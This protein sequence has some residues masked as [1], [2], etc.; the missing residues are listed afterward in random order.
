MLQSG[1]PAQN[2]CL[3][4]GGARCGTIARLCHIMM[5]LR[6]QLFLHHLFRPDSTVHGTPLCGKASGK[7]DPGQR[8]SALPRINLSLARC[9]GNNTTQ[10]GQQAPVRRL[11]FLASCWRRKAIQKP[12]L[13]LKAKHQWIERH[14]S[15]IG[16][17]MQIIAE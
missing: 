6:A 3:M 11:V 12:S 1:G 5:R 16:R 13:M 2:G 4:C 15:S 17:V 14:V 8:R 10:A 9:E 7:E